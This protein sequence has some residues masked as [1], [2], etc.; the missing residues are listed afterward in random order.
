MHAHSQYLDLQALAE[1][2]A[3]AQEAQLGPT[4][5]SSVA[6]KLARIS[7]VEVLLGVQ[8]F[9]AAES[10]GLRLSPAGERLHESGMRLLEDAKGIL[11]GV[12]EISNKPA[13]LVVFAAP[14]TMTAVLG[15]AVV[16]RFK[17]VF[18]SAHLHLIEGMAGHIREWLATGHVDAGVLLDVYGVSGYPLWTEQLKL[19]AHQSL[20]AHV[21]DSIA[22]AEL[23]R[24]P[25]LL[26]SRGHGIR[27]V[28]DR[29][30]QRLGIKLDVRL[31]GDSLNTLMD[32]VLERFGVAVLPRGAVEI[33]HRRSS[34]LRLIPIHSP[35]LELRFLLCTSGNKHP[36]ATV[37]ALVGIVR[38]EAVLLKP[39]WAL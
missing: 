30:A 13:G 32:W 27:Q 19:V 4:P 33:H 28:I 29:H 26:P 20:V 12:A 37:R 1:F 9:E 24:L 7:R 22:F 11:R 18:G 10:D 14:P 36:S 34:V 16:S 39:A 5:K 3:I 2:V 21:G 25:M 15:G 17:S 6:G 31:E 8:L 35:S 23:A 38:E